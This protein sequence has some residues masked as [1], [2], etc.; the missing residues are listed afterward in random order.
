M[1]WMPT[2]VEVIHMV[3]VWVILFVFNMEG[4]YDD[5]C[6]WW[7]RLMRKVLCGLCGFGLI[8]HKGMCIWMK[9]D[10]CFDW[11]I[12]WQWVHVVGSWS[13]CLVLT[14]YEVMRWDYEW[15]I[16]W[17]SFIFCVKCCWQCVRSMDVLAWEC[18]DFGKGEWFLMDV[19]EFLLWRCFWM[20]WSSL[21]WNCVS[22]EL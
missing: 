14:L 15:F 1:W 16:A 2:C 12:F 18:S 4:A 3:H 5:F 11:S 10:M 6:C 9:L 8:L 17:L 13:N 20:N 22:N 7:A 21:N 19:H